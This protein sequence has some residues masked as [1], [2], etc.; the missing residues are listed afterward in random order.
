MLGS[1]PIAALLG[2]G[3]DVRSSQTVWKAYLRKLVAAGASVTMLGPDVVVPDDASDE[4]LAALAS[5]VATY[6][7]GSQMPAEVSGVLAELGVVDSQG[8]RVNRRVS[9][10]WRHIT[11]VLGTTLASE[12][13]ASGAVTVSAALHVGTSEMVSVMVP[14]GDALSQWRSWSAEVSGD[15]RERH[16]AP[17]IL[18]PTAPGG[19]VYLFRT[20]ESVPTDLTLPV[21]GCTIKTGDMIVPIPPTRQ[22][23][24]PVARL[25][26]ARMLPAWLRRVLDESADAAERRTNVP[27]LQQI[28]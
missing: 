16:S 7:P 27:V 6:P 26:P 3:T 13:M 9:S 18:L 25:G 22:G 28:I 8:E 10:Y 17:T 21:A 15:R 23:G 1:D 19:G 12:L 2:A 20:S 4:V 11:K 14:D 5:L 24:K